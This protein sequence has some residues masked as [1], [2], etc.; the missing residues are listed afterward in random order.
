[1][2]QLRHV[3]GHLGLSASPSKVIQGVRQQY[4]WTV[5]YQN[6]RASRNS[7]GL[8]YSYLHA[9]SYAAPNM[10]PSP[11]HTQDGPCLSY[12]SPRLPY[13]F[14][15]PH[16]TPSRPKRANGRSA[17]GPL[18]QL[19]LNLIPHLHLDFNVTSQPSL[20][21]S[22]IVTSN[23]SQL[24]ASSTHS[25]SRGSDDDTMNSQPPPPAYQYAYPH[26]PPP[27]PQV[28]HSRVAWWY[29]ITRPWA[30]VVPFVTIIMDIWWFSTGRL[31]G[32]VDNMMDECFWVLWLSFPLVRPHSPRRLSSSTATEDM[33][34][35]YTNQPRPSSP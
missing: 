30:I 23:G 31:C 17:P 21:L 10:R 24:F 28:H 13:P 33:K 2:V 7:I 5:S 9:T 4:L 12:L 1:M 15:H 26:P 16:S 34:E 22:S 11:I 8:I 3:A 29:S 35:S 14:A 32:Y 19:R 27:P 25:F 20:S 6:S 18:P